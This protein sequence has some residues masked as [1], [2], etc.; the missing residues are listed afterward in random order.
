MHCIAKVGSFELLTNDQIIQF[1]APLL[2]AGMQEANVVALA[3]RFSEIQVSEPSHPPSEKML[4]SSNPSQPT[5]TFAPSV[6]LT[7]T[8]ASDGEIKAKETLS[9]KSMASFVQKSIKSTEAWILELIHMIDTG[10]QPE[11]M[12]V[13][14]SVVH[15]SNLTLLVLNLLHSLDECPKLS[16]NEEGK[17]L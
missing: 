14:P 2:I 1:L 15:N 16:L 11:F 12:E 13:M 17:A 5:I 9:T 7:H 8:S 4:A 10:G 6:P 3:N